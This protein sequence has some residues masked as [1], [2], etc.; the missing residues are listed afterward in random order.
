MNV[1]VKEIFDCII[2]SVYLCLMLVYKRS[3]ALCT[4]VTKKNATEH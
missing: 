2:V 4:M 3:S 1:S